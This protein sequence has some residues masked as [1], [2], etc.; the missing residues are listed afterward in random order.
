MNSVVASLNELATEVVVGINVLLNE[1]RYGIVSELNPEKSGI[2]TISKEWASNEIAKV[3]IID[4]IENTQNTTKINAVGL[5][6]I[7]EFSSNPETI[8]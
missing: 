3:W 8:N 5:A 6:Q 2:D 7:L 1:E 4:K